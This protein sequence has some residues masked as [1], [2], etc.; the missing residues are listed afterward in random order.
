M[1]NASE[2]DA[3]SFMLERFERSPLE[4]QGTLLFELD[5]H[6]AVASDS[7]QRLEEARYRIQIYSEFERDYVFAAAILI[8][9][10][11]LFQTADFAESVLEIDD[12]LC[13]L[14]HDAMQGLT[15]ACKTESNERK[16]LSKR[17]ETQLAQMSV[18]VLKRLDEL[19]AN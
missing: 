3:K 13:L 15:E 5:D 19:V 17:L 2:G 14:H 10:E 4:F 1:T 18:E 16:T 6:V 12:L 9:D 11:I 7:P 8:N